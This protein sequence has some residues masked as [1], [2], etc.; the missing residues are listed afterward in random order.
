MVGTGSPVL[1]APSGPAHVVLRV[2]VDD[3]PVL[4]LD[5]LLLLPRSVITSIWAQ[6]R[7]LWKSIG[8][9]QVRLHQEALPT[10]SSQWLEV[11]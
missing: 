8:K 6:G 1:A 4:L 10:F 11:P 2:T 7:G 3:L 5:H 9:A